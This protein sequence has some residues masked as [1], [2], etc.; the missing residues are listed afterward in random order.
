M[1]NNSSRMP[2]H[3]QNPALVKATGAQVNPSWESFRPHHQHN[4]E[5][6]PPRH[7]MAAQAGRAVVG[8]DNSLRLRLRSQKLELDDNGYNVWRDTAES[9]RVDPTNAALI[10]CDVWDTH[11]SRGA[12][13][14][15][16]KLIPRMDA[17]VK[18][19]RERE[20]LIV[21][22]PSDTM[23]AYESAPARLRAQNALAVEPPFERKHDD[24]P[25]PIVS[26]I[27]SVMPICRAA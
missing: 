16:D 3:L 8:S 26:A 23:D 13:E 1:P 19:A 7:G 10:L 5:Q 11:W 2:L 20:V 25:L 17:T 4:R 9:L 21:H 6:R 14:R 27:T 18:A 15:L 12:R 24:P 22:A